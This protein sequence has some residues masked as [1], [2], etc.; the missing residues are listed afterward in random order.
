[1]GIAGKPAPTDA[2][3]YWFR[4]RRAGTVSVKNLTFRFAILIGVA[5]LAL[6]TLLSLALGAYPISISKLFAGE[7]TAQDWSILTGLRA[8]RVL[9]A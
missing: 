5:A 2:T 7:L 4:A 6:A 9:A 3:T 8:P 1:M